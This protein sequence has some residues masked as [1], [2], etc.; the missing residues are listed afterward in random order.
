MNNEVNN[1]M[2]YFQNSYY[3]DLANSNELKISFNIWAAVFGAGWCFYRKLYAVGL[4]YF[5]IY[6]IFNSILAYILSNTSATTVTV[7]S[8]IF[9]RVSLGFIVNRIYI[10]R[11]LKEIDKIIT[12]EDQENVASKLKAAGGVSEIAV[13]IYYVVSIGFNVCLML[14][15]IKL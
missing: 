8:L 1:K 11:S 6:L 9:F 2:Q 5:F 13:V 3:V 7:I 15:G 10:N 4:V 12:T 14:A